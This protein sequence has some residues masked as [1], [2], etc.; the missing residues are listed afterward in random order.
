MVEPQKPWM[1]QT[2]DRYSK[3]VTTVLSLSTGSLVLPS[4]F[5]REFLGVPKEKALA[6][7]LNTWA[8]IGWGCLGVSILFGLAYSWLSVKWVKSAW[9]Q[10]TWLSEDTLEFLMDCSFVL[11]LILF[12]TGIA[13]TVGFFIT[14]HVIG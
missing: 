5:L 1:V 4:L 6:P 7:Y 2:N 13:A 10:A 11:M 8:Y 14:F 3:I 12:L 9:G